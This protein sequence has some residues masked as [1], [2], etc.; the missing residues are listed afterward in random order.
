MIKFLIRDISASFLYYTSLHES[1]Q[2]IIVR[3]E[4]LLGHGGILH[5]DRFGVVAKG[6]CLAENDE[7]AN[8]RSYSEDP[9][10]KSVENHRYETPI[11]IFRVELVLALYVVLNEHHVVQSLLELE[12]IFFP[13]RHVAQGL[14]Q[15]G[16]HRGKSVVSTDPPQESVM[17]GCRVQSVASADSLMTRGIGGRDYRGRLHGGSD[18]GVEFALFPGSPS[19]VH[20]MGGKIVQQ[21][22]GHPH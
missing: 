8:D 16:H 6:R 4:L 12:R 3:K 20:F 7:R 18:S 17:R 13:G 5:V 15:P 11:L 22:V 2:K 10:E 14:V 9:E 19:A 21:I 1:F